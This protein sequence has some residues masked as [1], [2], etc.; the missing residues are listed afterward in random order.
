MDTRLTR[1]VRSDLHFLAI[2]ET[3]DS[4]LGWMRQLVSTGEVGEL[5]LRG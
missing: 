2:L 3:Q 4:R 5:A 1:A